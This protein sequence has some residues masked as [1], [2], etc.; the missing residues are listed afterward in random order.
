MLLVIY[1]TSNLPPVKYV[2]YLMSYLKVF[3]VNMWKRV[4]CPAAPDELPLLELVFRLY[5]YRVVWV[6][7]LE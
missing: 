5:S 7:K 1:L 2:R 4:A 6:E 3:C